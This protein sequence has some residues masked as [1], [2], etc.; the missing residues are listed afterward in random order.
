MGND[1]LR[2]DR[3]GSQPARAAR[4]AEWAALGDW[5]GAPPVL[6]DLDV[7]VLREGLVFVGRARAFLTA[8]EAEVITEICRREGDSA[9]EEILRQ[10]QKRSRSGARK[11]VKTAGQLEWAPDVA[12]KLAEGAITPE[13]AGLILDAAGEAPIDEPALL[14]AAEDQP[15]DQFRRTLKE[16]I[17]ERTSEQELEARR[18]RQRRR[19]RASISEQGDGMFHLFAQLDPLTGAKVQAALIAKSDQLFRNEDPKDRPTA[20]QRFADALAELICDNA[21]AGAPAGAELI[22]LADYDSVHEQITN[23]RLT[24]GGRKE[25]GRGLVAK[26]KKDQGLD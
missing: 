15:E 7:E 19:R 1:P 20:P 10:D 18:E 17:N 21:G 5:L 2:E 22:V 26:I 4:I 16:H 14:E 25:L 24:D 23:A 11:A 9:T 13:V 6:R 3:V 12:D 8:L